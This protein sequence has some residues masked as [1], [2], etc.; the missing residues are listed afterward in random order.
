MHRAAQRG[1][2]VGLLILDESF[3]ELYDIAW[4]DP[5]PEARL[6]GIRSLGVLDEARFVEKANLRALFER[7]EQASRAG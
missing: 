4:R 6:A 3:P 7:A 5:C 1:Q 2:H